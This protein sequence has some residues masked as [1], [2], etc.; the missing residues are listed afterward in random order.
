[1]GI[2][3]ICLSSYNG[4]QLLTVTIQTEEIHSCADFHL[5]MSSGN[6]ASWSWI[7][8]FLSA[9][10]SCS[11]LNPGLTVAHL[12]QMR[13]THLLTLPS[14]WSDWSEDVN[15]HCPPISGDAFVIRQGRCCAG[16]F[17]N[18]FQF[19]INV[20]VINYHIRFL[21]INYFQINLSE[22][23]VISLDIIFVIIRF[24]IVMFAVWAKQIKR[25]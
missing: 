10:K 13:G 19:P 5:F 4:F 20:N 9:H 21:L 23:N 3:A 18:V 7:Q 17:E 22:D 8:E 25:L 12:L 2:D 15:W 24:C 14:S 11:F 6:T 1:M 16:S